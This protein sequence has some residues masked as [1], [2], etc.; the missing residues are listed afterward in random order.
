MMNNFLYAM[1]SS[2]EKMNKEIYKVLNQTVYGDKEKNEIFFS[3]G[4]CLHWILDYA[5]R[6]NITEQDKGVISAFRFA[7]NCLKHSIVIKELTDQVG[8][9]EFLIEF[10]LEIPERQVIWSVIE[11]G[12]EKWKNQKQNYKILL[13]GKDVLKTCKNIIEIL[14]KY[15]L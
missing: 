11:S 4:T 15:E 3:V 12:D 10:P 6:V 1:K 8:G 5:E 2:F 13:E 9:I 14:E 7:N